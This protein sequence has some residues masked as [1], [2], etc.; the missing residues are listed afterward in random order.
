L[1]K[2]STRLSHTPHI[3][4]R[5][6]PSNTVRSEGAVRA[7]MPINTNTSAKTKESTKFVATPAAET[8]MSPFLYLRYLRG[9]TGTGLAP[10]NTNCPPDSRKV[11]AGKAMLMIGSMCGSG[12][13][14]IRPS[15]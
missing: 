9:F 11:I 7:R 13:S 12:L 15:M 2:Q 1:K 8:M 6:A 10:P 3:I 4:M 5:C 14:V